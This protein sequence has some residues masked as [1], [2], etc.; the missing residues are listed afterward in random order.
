[1]EEHDGSEPQVKL[2][3]IP[4]DMPDSLGKDGSASNQ[5]QHRRTNSARRS[6]AYRTYAER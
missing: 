5:A 2:S 1:M 4:R 3:E 6:A